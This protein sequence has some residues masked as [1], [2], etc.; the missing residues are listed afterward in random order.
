MSNATREWERGP[1][2]ARQLKMSRG[3]WLSCELTMLAADEDGPLFCR[4]SIMSDWRSV[5]AGIGESGS[6]ETEGR[7]EGGA[8]R[9]THRGTG[10]P[11]LA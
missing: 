8:G 3:R 10:R 11:A 9:A 4:G 2:Q 7:D 6:A 1:A 5:G